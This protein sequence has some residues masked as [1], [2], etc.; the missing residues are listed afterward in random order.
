MFAGT[1]RYSLLL[2]LLGA[3]CIATL[4]SATAAKSSR[5]KSVVT[6]LDAK[7]T[8]TSFLAETS[9]FLA[10]E[11]SQLFWDFIS[12][13]VDN[14]KPEQLS[15]WNEQQQYDSAIKQA[16]TLISPARLDLLKMALSVRAHSPGVELHRQIALQH[17]DIAGS[18]AA[19]VEVHGAVTCD[20]A[21]LESMIATVSGVEDRPAAQLFSIDHLFPGAKHAPVTAILYG[22]IGSEQWL[23]FHL[24]LK[25]LARNHRVKYVLRHYSLAKSERKV[26]LSGYGV[27]LAIKST[28]YKAQDDSQIKV[29]VT[30]DGSVIE[31]EDEEDL[32]GLNIR[33]LKKLHPELS[34]S[35]R[36]FKLHV[37]EA[38]ELTPLKVWEVQ[39]LS[40]Q[41]GQRVVSVG[42]EKGDAIQALIDIS[43]NFPLLARSLAR[44]G[45]KKEFRKEVESNQEKS[46]EEVGLSPGETGLFI[47][48]ISID[49]D[50][51]DVFQLLDLLKKEEKLSAGFF[52]MGFR[53]EYLSILMEL[54]PSDD[55][56]SYAVDVREAFPEF[57]NNLDT[58]KQYRGWGNSVKLMLQPYFPGMIRPIA[59][60]FFTLVFIVDPSTRESR[61]LLKIAYSF[62]NHEIPIRIGLVFAVNTNKEVSGMDDAGVALLNIYNFVKV[63]KKADV[64]LKALT[65]IFDELPDRDVLTPDDVVKH[66]TKKYPDEDAD[67]V[68]G[69]NSDYD[70]GRQ[71]GTQF[72]EK[73]GLGK[74]PKVLLNGIPLDDT[75]ITA[76]RFEETVINEITKVT[77]KIQ[78]AVMEGR[79]TDKDS[80][81]NWFLDQPEVMPRLNR[82]I[83]DA[84]KGENVKFLDLT[85]TYEYKAP[86]LK[87]FALLH[88]RQKNQVILRT[89]KHLK[90]NDELITRPVTVW[91]VGDLETSEGRELYYNAI[92]HLKQSHKTRIGFIHNPTNTEKDAKDTVIT[93]LVHGG[94]KLLTDTMSKQFV[95]KLVKEE[96]FVDL[97][98]GKLSLEELAV[99]GMDVATFKKELN[100]L[101][102]EF[103]KI[104]SR[105]AT[106]TLE[107]LPGQ[108]AIVANGLVIGPLDDGERFESEDFSLLEKYVAAR[109]GNVVAQHVDKWEVD[110]RHDKSSDVVLRASALV[111]DDPVKKKRQWIILQNDEHSAFTTAAQDETT[112]AFDIVAVVDPL[113]RE[114]QKLAP[115]LSVLRRVVNADVKVVMNPRPKLSELPLKRFFRLVLEPELQFASDGALRHGPY[116]RFSSLPQKQLLTLNLISPDA[117]M[118]EA[119]NAV[120]DLDNIKMEMVDSDVTAEYELEHLLL[121]GHC[122]DE[123]SGAP[124]RGLQFTLG[125][126]KQ[127]EEVDTIVMANLGYFQ[128]KANP[129][130]WLL[131]LREGRSKDIYDITTHTNTESLPHQPDVKVLLDSFAGKTI[132]IRVAKKPEM[133][134][135]SLLNDAGDG[136]KSDESGG[137]SIWKSLSSSFNGGA[138]GKYEEIN[139]FSLASG[140]LYE[141]FMRIMIVSV[142]KNTKHPVKFWLLKNY[143]SP[144]FKKFLPYMS[145]Q[146]G[147]QY[148]LVQYKWPRWLHQQTEKHRVMWGYKILF[149]DVLFPLD[150]KK[151][152]FVDAD[153][154][155]RADL[156]ELMELDLNG[157]PYGFTPFCDSRT[158]MEGFRFWKRGYWANHLAGRKYHISALYVIDLKKFRQIAAGDR[159]R[160]QYQGLSADPNSLSNLDQDLPNN[161]V[162]QVR[163]KSLPQ[164]W[165][166]CETWCDDKSKGS[167][168]TIDL[169]NNPQT[170]EP[171]L[172]SAI[173]IIGEWKDYDSELKALMAR[174]ES[175]DP[176]A[177]PTASPH[178][179]D[180][181]HDHDHG[182]L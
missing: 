158:E 119:V 74:A 175:G 33:L 148:E 51:L 147:F 104:H 178:A 40:F 159:L 6:S 30:E 34:D 2:G 99:N 118:V 160:G 181:K 168:K 143:L 18:C 124:P 163:I 88:E 128:L 180:H 9:E 46:F 152:I 27:E 97:Q 29:N 8:Q 169:C 1:W 165:L 93:K 72:L 82:R 52:R 54:D 138:G 24:T 85:D 177:E 140:H 130:A 70:N 92:K 96:N 103:L 10:K 154:V 58:D 73:S 167:A 83:L 182:D 111:S 171:K 174:Y 98:K 173:R 101:S 162:H 137:D 20:V 45:V 142:M 36:Q 77:P 145:A 127:P 117:W 126:E 61:N 62:Y 4:A 161:M 11:S 110:K 132:R 157:A 89:M 90:R 131:R 149:L 170:K 31:E 42:K 166:W 56:V 176:I 5:Q 84:G 13:V 135:E 155:V 94:L 75:G 68:F 76:D 26:R 91:V 150:V 146:Y 107:L 48:G 144:Q 32:N 116:A 115:V 112:A 14:S 19:F 172:E 3:C 95:T 87:D 106:R 123:I 156:M 41:A 134:K 78:K 71:A 139:I 129:G 105:Y 100:L 102:D 120:H 38:D 81:M 65:Q 50:T 67:L 64:A 53:R 25:A 133:A 80:V 17:A 125:T 60:N 151:I 47:N 109:S 57:L 153:Q 108:R 35:L 86:T 37:L 28:E 63:D 164:E 66:F 22:D 21:K 122:F 113:S 121:E 43:Q 136:D 44:Q 7:W 141:R 55:A 114:A 49:L 15:K 12:N 69:V 79:L 179:S 39:D 16:S 23:E 59:R